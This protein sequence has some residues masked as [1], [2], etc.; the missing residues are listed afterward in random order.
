MNQKLKW[1]LIA[2]LLVGLILGATVLYQKLSG[3]YEREKLA[4]HATESTEAT[5]EESTATQT[6]TT[7]ESTQAE[8]QSTPAPDFTV[9]DGS[10]N[11]V[12]LSDYRGKPVVLN[13]WATWCHYCKVEMPDFDTACQKYPEVQFLMINATDGMRETVEG[14]KAYVDEEGYTFE[15]FFDTGSEA[16]NAYGISAFPTTFFIDENGNLVAHGSGMLD[17]ETLERGI[18]MILPPEA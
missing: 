16:V 7:E 10:G 14:A 15:V 3:D 13:F 9:L 1:I 6:E 17:L 18:A 5:A 4:T 12:R 8:A 2:V 11:P